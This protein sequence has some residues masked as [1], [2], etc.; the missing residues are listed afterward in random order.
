MKNR[1]GILQALDELISDRELKTGRGILKIGFL[2]L[3]CH[4]MPSCL[5]FFCIS[6]LLCVRNIFPGL[7]FIICLLISHTKEAV[8]PEHPDLPPHRKGK[9]NEHPHSILSRQVRLIEGYIVVPRAGP[10]PSALEFY[11][12]DVLRRIEV[13]AGSSSV[14]VNETM[15][16]I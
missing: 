9:I 13:Q 12:S 4:A 3:D 16:S 10:R 8:A 6:W 2:S 7:L 11:I 5:S 15:V 14:T 1:V